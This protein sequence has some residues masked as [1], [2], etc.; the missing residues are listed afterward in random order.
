[1][2][3]DPKD[4][5]IALTQHAHALKGS[6]TLP[7]SSQFRTIKFL[8]NTSPSGKYGQRF[9]QD[10]EPAGMYFIEDELGSSAVPSGWTRGTKTFQNPLVVPW[11]SNYDAYSWK[12]TL[13]NEFNATGRA[14][15][16]R[17]LKEGYDAIVT[18]TQF[19]GKWATSE[20]VDLTSIGPL[21]PNKTNIVGKFVEL[22]HGTSRQRANIIAKEGFRIGVRPQTM[23]GDSESNR[24]YI[25]LAKRIESAKSYAAMYAQPVI[26]T[27]R[28]PTTLLKKIDPDGRNSG[29]DSVWIKEEIPAKYIY[30]IT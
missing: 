10:I 26:I 20:M 21:A 6:G 8:H 5:E 29:P 4:F 12:A 19:Q 24:Q 11:S 3:Y 28:I 1:M 17:L 16:L 25:W 9:Q 18:V 7:V 30:S 15:S 27:V 14:L 22:Y 23:Q 2:K 13:R